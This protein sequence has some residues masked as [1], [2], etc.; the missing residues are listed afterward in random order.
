MKK[1]ESILTLLQIRGIGP[2]KAGKIINNSFDIKNLK[3]LHSAICKNYKKDH[4]ISLKTLE[5]YYQES[6]N[7]CNLAKKEGIEIIERESSYYPK[8]FNTLSNSP[9]ILFA[10]GNIKLLNNEKLISVVGTRNPSL[11][12]KDKCEKLIYEFVKNGLTIVSGLA[13][14]CDTIAHESCLK[15][16]GSTIAILPSALDNIYPKQNIKLADEII[17]N[18]GLILSEYLINKED[19][20]INKSQFIERNRLVASLPNSLCIIESDIK[21]GTM[22]TYKY[23]EKYNKLVGVINYLSNNANNSGNKYLI[24]KKNVFS[25]NTIKEVELFINDVVKR[26]EEEAQ[27]LILFGKINN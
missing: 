9:I 22:Q 18:D 12:G 14:G 4:S 26:K 16:K 3:D 1:R 17:N 27:Q 13:I 8:R 10:K 25:I 21:G 7:I 6:L 15:Y 2:Q 19:K 23:A 11:L 24:Q 5:L 20:K